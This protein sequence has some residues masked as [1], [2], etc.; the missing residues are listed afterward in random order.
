MNRGA[1]RRAVFQTDDICALFL[2]VVGEAARLYG[3]RV[4]GYALMPNHYHLMVETPR[5]NLSDFMR[6]VGGVFSQRL[7]RL[8]GWDGPVFRGR[9]RNRVVESDAYWMHLLA[10]LH[11]NPVKAHLTPR[12]EDCPWTS[13]AAYVGLSKPPEW[14]VCEELT[15]IFGG[16]AAVDA[17]VRNVHIGRRE[18]PEGFDAERL[19]RASSTEQAPLPEAPRPRSADE[20][21]ADVAR[22]TGV[23]VG[24]LHERARTPLGNPVSWLAAWWLCRVTDLTQAQVAGLLGV[25]RPRVSQIRNQLSKRARTDAEVDRWMRALEQ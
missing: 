5:G 9:F 1:R 12:P 2:G 22:V 23:P 17:Y 19:W 14:L 24:S 15:A 21:L 20:A 4:H 8:G 25:S 10:Y 13:H 16:T 7:N 18:A 3:V 6:Q 11:L